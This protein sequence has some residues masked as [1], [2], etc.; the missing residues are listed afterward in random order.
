[1]SVPASIILG[2]IS[3]LQDAGP[4]L[5]TTLVL[6]S[7]SSVSCFLLPMLTCSIGGA[8]APDSTGGHARRRRCFT[9]SASRAAEASAMTASHGKSPL[10]A[11]PESITASAPSQ[12]ALQT[13]LTSARVGTGFLIILSTTCVALMTKRPACFARAM[14]SFCAK[15]TRFRPSSTPRSPRA[16]MRAWDFAMMP[17]MFVKACGFSIFG[18]IFGRRSGGMFSR[19][20]MSMSSCK[21][22]PFWTK[23]TQMY[24]IGGSSCKRYSASSMSFAVNAAQSISRSGTLTPLRA[25]NFPPRVT[26]TFNSVDEIFSVTFTSIKPSSM[27]RIVPTLHASTKAFCSL[28]GFMVIRPGLIVSLSSLQM[29]N[30]KM[31]PFLRSTGS[32]ASSPTRN[33][34]P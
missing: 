17:S 13:S 32:A 22:C 28:V 8:N 12:T 1:M 11:S 3:S 9:D 14:S 30:S 23:D 26:S 27:S 19:S 10:A 6:R 2:I 5:A 16:T 4:R 15:G 25:F 7:E 34:G 18:Q 29:P 24:S 21:S 31:S 33:L 20:I